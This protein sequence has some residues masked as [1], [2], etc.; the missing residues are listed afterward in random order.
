MRAAEV[1]TAR[2]AV[3][4]PAARTSYQR[5]TG[6]RGARRRAIMHRIDDASTK[7]N[8]SMYGTGMQRGI[9]RGTDDQGGASM[10]GVWPDP[11]PLQ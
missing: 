5:T 4:P 6:I 10:Y 7:N 3:H 1:A 9:V 11:E 8:T 2:I